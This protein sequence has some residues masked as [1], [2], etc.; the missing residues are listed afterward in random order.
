MEVEQNYLSPYQKL[1]EV[2]KRFYENQFLFG[3]KVMEAAMKIA[4]SERKIA[5]DNFFNIGS[6]RI[7]FTV[8]EVE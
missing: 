3:K 6:H 5:V 1:D 8:E 7:K 4:S 2:Q